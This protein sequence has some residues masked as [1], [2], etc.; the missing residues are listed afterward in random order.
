MALSQCFSLPLRL[1]L[2]STPARKNQKIIWFFAHLFVPLR[3]NYN[4]KVYG[5]QDK[6]VHC[7][8]LQAV[9]RR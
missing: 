5:Q 7:R 2:E 6:Q 8:L 3:P 9:R 1:R 4:N